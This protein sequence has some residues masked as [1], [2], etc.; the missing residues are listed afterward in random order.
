MRPGI[1]LQAA[2]QAVPRPDTWVDN[3]PLTSSS[4][5]FIYLQT[6]NIDIPLEGRD[7]DRDIG[8]QDIHQ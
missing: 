1:S 3:Q 5:G 4:V 8:M 7:E 2:L 6:N